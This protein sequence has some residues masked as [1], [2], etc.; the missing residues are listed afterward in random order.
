MNGA[1]EVLGVFLNGSQRIYNFPA[2]RIHRTIVHEALLKEL[3]HQGIPTHYEKKCVG[4]KE[5][6]QS[7]ATVLFEDGSTVD[8]ELII[9]A[10]GIHS[11]V[12]PFIAPNSEAEFSGLMGVMGTV[13]ADDLKCTLKDDGLHLPCMLFGSSGSFAIMPASHD[14]HELGYFATIEAKDRGRE[15]WQQLENKKEELKSM[16]NDRFLPENLGWPP[17][18]KELCE[19]AAPDTL[20]SWP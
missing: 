3:D 16:L 5:E 14:G 11:R 1:G 9:G 2:L 17:L 4:V 8:A 6:T 12:R 15:G 20:T 7:G 13:M 18:V 10:D 19:K